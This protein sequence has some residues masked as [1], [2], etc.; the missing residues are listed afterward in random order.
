MSLQEPCAPGFRLRGLPFAIAFLLGGLFTGGAG[1]FEQ[2]QRINALSVQFGTDSFATANAFGRAFVSNLGQSQMNT[3]ISNQIASGTVSILFEML[4]LADLTG[5]NQPSFHVGVVNGLP[6]LTTNNPTVYSG[7]SDLDWWYTPNLRE[8]DASGVPS[9]QLPASIAASALDAGPG[10]LSLLPSATGNGWFDFSTVAIKATVGSSS[11]PLPSTHGFPPGHRPSEHLD[12]QLVSFASM[13]GGRLKGNI[14]AVSLA[15][16]PLSSGFAGVGGYIA[17]NSFLDMLV[18]GYKAFGLIT[19]VLPTQPD[20]SNPDAPAVG[21]GPPYHFAAGLDKRVNQAFDKHGA[22]VDLNA[23]LNA[24]A[25]SAYFTFTTDRVIVQWPP[26]V[27][28]SI[29]HSANNVI[30][31]W[32][33]PVTGWTLQTNNNLAAATWG[34]YAGPVINN[35]VTNPLPTG[36]LFFRLTHP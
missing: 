11:A 6:V 28:L 22:I 19:V 26:D 14:S 12:P 29:T 16:T 1:A 31:S 25:Y 32:Q 24:A 34:N 5:T 21:A 27:S 7:Q 3:A 36:Y 18:S 33:S 17:T 15:A 4:G 35:S 13:S 2:D 23:A 9:T 30:V 8:L 20:Q 10:R